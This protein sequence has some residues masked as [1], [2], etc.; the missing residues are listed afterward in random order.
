M[1]IDRSFRIE[2]QL[3]QGGMGTVHQATELASGRPVAL[4]LVSQGEHPRGQRSVSHDLSY[5]LALAREFQTLAS[6]HHPNIIRVLNYGFD[7]VMGSYYTMELLEQPLTIL[8]AGQG[9]S[10]AQK[11]ELLAQLLRALVYVHQRKL[12]HR[13]IKPSNI[14]SIEKSPPIVR[15]RSEKLR[16]TV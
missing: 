15:N 4:K 3:G 5:R 16:T 10:E 2:N 11:A 12:L 8:E 9:K 6:L 13:D 1:I 14:T 7:E